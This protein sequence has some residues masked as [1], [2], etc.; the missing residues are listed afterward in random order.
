MDQ[1]L[2]FSKTREETI[3]HH[4]IYASYTE[5]CTYITWTELVIGFVN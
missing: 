2:S 3:S 1:I 4:L 5:A